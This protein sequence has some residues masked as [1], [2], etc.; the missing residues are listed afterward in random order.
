M[1]PVSFASRKGKL[2][3]YW[4]QAATTSADIIAMLLISAGL[5]GTTALTAHDSVATMLAASND[6]A[7][8]TNYSR[9]TVPTPTVTV[10]KPTD[11]VILDNG[12]V[13]TT[14]TWLNA[15]GAVNNVIGSLVLFYDPAPGSPVAANQLPLIATPI[16]YTTDGNHM[17]ITILPTG[18]A[19]VRNP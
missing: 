14:L 4:E 17:V 9:L 10:D 18:L 12:P 11:R 7:T 8:F 2:Q 3:W 6:E 15:G 1:D 16:G 5:Q 13:N 19:I